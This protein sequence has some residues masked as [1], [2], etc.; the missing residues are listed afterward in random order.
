MAKYTKSHPYTPKPKLHLSL[1]NTK[2]GKILNTNLLAGD[3]YCSGRVTS[4]RGSCTGCCLSCKGP[5]YARKAYRYDCV[6][7]ANSD[8]LYLATTDLK[9]FEDD[10]VNQINSHPSYSY[11]RWHSAGEIPSI[12]Y[13][14]MICRVC[15]RTPKV[16]HYIYT[17]RYYMI[18]HYLASHS[19]T[20][21]A[22]LKILFSPPF[23]CTTKKSLDNWEK[24]RNPY[25]LPLFIYDIGLEI[26]NSR[27]QSHCFQI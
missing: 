24:L 15:E 9:K 3:D 27:F 19:K 5:C 12:A 18:N 14:S 11:H 23:T 16:Q 17:K 26:V 6:I 22:N 10:L 13:L 25:S 1:G 20:L 4:L 7:E 21:P 2:I 8:N